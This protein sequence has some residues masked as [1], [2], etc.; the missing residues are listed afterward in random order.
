MV[1][2]ELIFNIVEHGEL[3]CRWGFIAMEYSI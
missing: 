2:I 3:D 1:E